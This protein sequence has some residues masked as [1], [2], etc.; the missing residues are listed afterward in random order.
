MNDVFYLVMENLMLS[1]SYVTQ[2]TRWGREVTRLA[3]LVI[4]TTLVLSYPSEANFNRRIGISLNL[5]QLLPVC[6]E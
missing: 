1:P 5:L 4:P 2:P 3:T 6:W